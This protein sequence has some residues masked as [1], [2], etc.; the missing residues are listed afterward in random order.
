M[1]KSFKFEEHFRSTG[2]LYFTSSVD[3]AIPYGLNKALLD[4]PY[5]DEDQ[6]KR[7]TPNYKDT[8]VIGVNASK[9]G[10]RVEA[11]PEMNLE[12]NRIKN[13]VVECY[14]YKGDIKLKHLFTCKYRPFDTFDS[15]YVNEIKEYI[16]SKRASGEIMMKRIGTNSSLLS[17]TL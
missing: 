10:D 4:M 8:V 2:Y 15:N 1:S 11:D 17:K 16:S 12:I 13:R 5:M 9:L 7:I 14:R 3:H 6:A